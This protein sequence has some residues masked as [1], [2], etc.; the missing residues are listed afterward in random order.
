MLKFQAEEEVE[1]RLQQII[2]KILEKAEFLL[3][4]Q[5]P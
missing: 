5:T 4:L 1:Q 3:K 2:D